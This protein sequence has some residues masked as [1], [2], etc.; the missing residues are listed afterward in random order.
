MSIIKQYHK[1]TNTTYVYESQYYYDKDKK[2]SRSKRKLIG[3]IDE[4]TGQ[5]V[6]TGK[7]GRK[8][9]AA[10]GEVGDQTSA[11]ERA[12]ADADGIKELRTEIEEQKKENILLRTHMESMEERYMKLLAEKDDTVKKLQAQ[13]KK[14]EG[15][16]GRAKASLTKAIGSLE[17][18]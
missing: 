14:L 16:I 13:V 12:A 4:E 18:A 5:I 7:R 15:V 6:P 2:Q 3:K 9:K 8:K 11:K 1:D 17:D 10:S